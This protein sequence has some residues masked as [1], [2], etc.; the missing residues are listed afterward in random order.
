MVPAHAHVLSSSA[1][2]SFNL[3]FT[4]DSYVRP[5]STESAGSQR[6]PPEE[7][8]LST[9][10]SVIASDSQSARPSASM[11]RSGA[12][13]GSFVVTQMS[14]LGGVVSFDGKE[15]RLT[16]GALPENE[17]ASSARVDA[18]VASEGARPFPPPYAP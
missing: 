11:V 17:P 6:V 5:A 2:A 8:M 9:N 1:D 12:A 14:T 4:L 7:H 13:E 10:V 3:P 16:S 18:R 15:S